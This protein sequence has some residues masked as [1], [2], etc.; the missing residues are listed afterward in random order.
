MQHPLNQLILQGLLVEMAPLL[1]VVVEAVAAP[2]VALHLPAAAAAAPL[3]ALPLPVDKQQL[4][5]T[6]QKTLISTCWTPRTA[7]EL[8]KAQEESVSK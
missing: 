1:P 5:V 4:K 2:L 8:K 7:L 3:A 6:Q